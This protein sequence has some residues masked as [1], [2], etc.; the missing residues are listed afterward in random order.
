MGKEDKQAFIFIPDISGFTAFVNN[1]EISHSQHIITELLELII[2]ANELQMEVSEVEGD[3]VLF[4]RFKSVPTAEEVWQQSRNMFLKFHSHLRHYDMHRICQC[5][6]CSTAS[7]LTL[8]MIAHSGELDRIKIK[9]REKLHG[10][11]L[12]M[13]H[14]LLK[15]EVHEREYLLVTDALFNEDFSEKS[16]A[17]AQSTYG[18][19]GEVKYHYRTL[20]HLHR[21][22]SDPPPLIDA[23]F[24]PNPIKREIFV[25]KPVAQVFELVTNM[26]HRKL[27][28]TDVP[29]ITYD[30]NEINQVGSKHVCVFDNRSIEFETVKEDFGSGKLVY[31]ERTEEI[32]VFKEMVTYFILE[33]SKGGTLLRIE[34]HYK[35]RSFFHS[36]IVPIF[37]RFLARQNDKVL[38]Q[39]K[40]VAEREAS[41]AAA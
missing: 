41:A 22:V 27:W 8:K 28:N 39:I 17:A 40:A 2:D 15:N 26:E 13:A 30:P 24:I 9:E 37:R 3:A 34:V 11:S 7:Q 36:L 29:K 14:R 38:R 31:G 25:D 1:T 12:I 33:E 19:L 4:Y 20:T 23:N 32:P 6:A 35:P 5:G 21:E 18:E 10:S 16:W